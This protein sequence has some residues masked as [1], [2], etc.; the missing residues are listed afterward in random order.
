VLPF[1]L[2]SVN[3]LGV[4]SV[5][6]P[7]ANRVRIWERI[8]KDLPLDALDALTDVIG[9]GDVPSAANDILKGQVRG[10]LVVDVNA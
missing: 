4:D 7:A 10:R 6:Q 1:L 2:R 8:A 3:L 5:M 9:L